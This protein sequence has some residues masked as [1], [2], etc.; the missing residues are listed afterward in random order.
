METHTNQVTAYPGKWG[1]MLAVGLG[2][3]IGTLDMS[4]V[5][6][7][8]PTLVEQLQTTFATVQWVVLGYALVITSTILGAARLGD[9]YEKKKLY[10]IGLIVFT[11]GSL[12]CGL[13]PNIGWL[14]AFRVLQGCGG[15]IAQA[16]GTAI[17]VEAFPPYERGRALGIVGSISAMGISLGPA[18]GGLIIGWVGWR[19]VFL[20]KVPIG[21]IASLATLRFLAARPP[22]QVNQ[23]FDVTGAF[24]L[25]ITLCC[26]ALGMTIGQY[27]GFRSSL[28][29]ALL[30]FSIIGMALFLYVENKVKHPM[31]D[32]SLFHNIPFSLNLMTGLATAIPLGGVFIIP[33]FLQLVKHYSPQKVGLMM[34]VTPLTVGLIAL[35]SGTLSDR[36][37][38]RGISLIGLFIAAAGCL[39]ISTLNA[40]TDVLGYLL[41]VGPLGV[42]MGLFISPNLSAVMGAAPPE[43]LGVAS[44]LLSLTRNLGQTIG[45]PVMGAI[46]TSTLLTAANM[47]TLTDL[48]A[49]PPQALVS[50]VASAYRIGAL[51]ILVSIMLLVAGL[52]IDKNRRRATRRQDE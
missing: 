50:G 23:S 51:L 5:N 49:A 38:T 37:G 41:K 7:S 29:L 3:F 45:M 2:A 40:D 28:V 6:I 47:S 25:L 36:Y 22:R 24:I 8:L 18:I 44:G 12:L 34:M 27:Q 39:S 31:V 43:R 48:T 4:I 14:I 52:W 46:F 15:V 17:I 30:I 16:L 33:F 9:I 20:I 13:S 21:I 10:N 19:W 26:F 1:A 35:Y 11:I 32:L 42:G